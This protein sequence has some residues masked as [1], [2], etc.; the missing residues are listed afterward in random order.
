MV[1]TPESYL[2]VLLEQ[3]SGV[4]PDMA[5]S[6]RDLSTF[7]TAYSDLQHRYSVYTDTER[8]DVGC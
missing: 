6:F 2:P 3:D 1:L 4:N 7:D 8:K 5:Q